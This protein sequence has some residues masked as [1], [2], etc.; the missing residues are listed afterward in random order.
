MRNR[1]SLSSRIRLIAGIPAVFS[2]FAITV[3]SGSANAQCNKGK[4]QQPRWQP[5][6]P[7]WQPQQPQ[8]QPQQP[9]PGQGTNPPGQCSGSIPQP[10]QALNPSDWNQV[11]GYPGGYP[12]NEDVIVDQNPQS[13]SSQQNSQKPPVADK[14]DN[15]PADNSPSL[16][17]QPAGP[18][19]QWSDLPPLHGD[20]QQMVHQTVNDLDWLMASHGEQFSAAAADLL[21][22]AKSQL[23]LSC[24]ICDEDPDLF[25]GSS[26]NDES[27]RNVSEQLRQY[28]SLLNSTLE[29]AEMREMLAIISPARADSRKLNAAFSLL[30]DA[31][32]PRMFA[33]F[34]VETLQKRATQLVGYAESVESGT[35]QPVAEET[36]VGTLTANTAA[37]DFSLKSIDGKSVTLGSLRGKKVVLVFSRGHF[38]PYCMGQ[39]RQLM[40]VSS[41]LQAANTEVVIVFRELQPGAE[42]AQGIDG[43]R[44]FQQQ[45]NAPFT[46]ATDFGSRQTDRYSPNGN[47]STYILDEQGRILSVL[48]GVKYIRPSA[49]AILNAVTR[50]RP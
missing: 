50:S 7:Q 40:A 32:R 47:F 18:W 10:P 1:N 17:S 49:Q 11:G 44:R 45:A 15:K 21:R 26:A 48:E 16:D 31:S 23:E 3:W 36:S 4:Q 38:C 22:E 29:L 19:D 9:W 14:P 42:E 8:W 28:Q 5:Q 33:L 34:A 30:D 2:L 46:L 20:F 13:N 6:Q 37:P 39:V 43:L 25:A 12:G 24:R 27:I 41:Q 35:F